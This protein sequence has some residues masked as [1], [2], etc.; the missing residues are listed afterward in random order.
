MGYR[1]LK[2]ATPQGVFNLDDEEPCAWRFATAGTAARI[3]PRARGLLGLR[4]RIEAIGGTMRLTTPPGAGAALSVALP[5][6]T[7]HCDRRL[8]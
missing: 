3:R 7:Q 4:D 1:D 8:Q 2:E 5:L 6:R